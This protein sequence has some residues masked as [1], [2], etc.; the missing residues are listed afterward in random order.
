MDMRCSYV[1]FLWYTFCVSDSAC[2]FWLGFYHKYPTKT[3]RALR[4]LYD[5]TTRGGANPNAKLQGSLRFYARL[6][7]STMTTTA[8][9]V[10]L[11]SLALHVAH[12]AFINHVQSKHRLQPLNMVRNIDLPEAL[13]FYG[14]HVFEDDENGK[15]LP[16]VSSLIAECKDIETPVVVILTDDDSTIINND[17]DVTVIPA[18]SCKPP[19]PRALYEAV[20]SLTIQPRGFGGS[21]GFG[22]K[23]ADPERPPEFQHV[24]VFCN[25]VQ[26]CR[27][28][29]Y[30]GA[31]VVCKTDNDLADAIVDEWDELCVD[32][33]ATP[34]SYWLNPPHPKDDEGNRVD[35][36]DIMDYY[37][38][39]GREESDDDDVDAESETSGPP[40]MDEDEMAR[41]LADL[42]TI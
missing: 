26:V 41:I 21:S 25:D 8:L 23:A 3:C 18:S 12:A 22:R 6:K 39:G 20:Q 7:T 9:V 37:E 16:G 24:V 28:A 35:I 33:V 11:A 30:V 13:V 27:A 34:G 19:N 31:R 40:T 2:H 32:D 1:C 17:N 4:R 10:L 38:N 14:K 42:D 5:G 36:Y 29:R 15:L